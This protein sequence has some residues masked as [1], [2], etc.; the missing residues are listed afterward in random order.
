M[1]DGA[2]H[3]W[4][5]EQRG[6]ARH[7]LTVEMPRLHAELHALGL[8]KTAHALHAA[9][10]SLGWEIAEHEEREIKNGTLKP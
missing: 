3:R 7:A 1:A 6:R 4:T 9:V 10:Q 5:P 8:H 2:Y